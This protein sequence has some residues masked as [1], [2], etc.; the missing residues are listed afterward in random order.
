MLILGGGLADK[1]GSMKTENKLYRATLIAAYVVVLL[2]VT[3]C[4]ENVGP[5]DGLTE[6]RGTTSV[7]G[8]VVGESGL[9][10]PNSLVQ[11]NGSSLVTQA[12]GMLQGKAPTLNN[13]I[14]SL[15]YS[16][17]GL[18]VVTTVGVSAYSGT[19]PLN[20]K[21]PD[22]TEVRGAVADGLNI[23]SE[24]YQ[25]TVPPRSVIGK[26]GTEISDVNLIVGVSSSGKGQGGSFVSGT[27][28]TRSSNLL[29]TLNPMA[30]VVVSAA[31]ATHNLAQL[32]A[33]KTVKLLVASEVLNTVSRPDTVIVWRFDE[34]QWMWVRATDAVLSG[35]RYTMELSK[36]GSYVL[37]SAVA[38]ASISGRVIGA[39]G[40][41]LS[42]VDLMV[43]DA[44]ATTD[45]LGEFFAYVPS[46]T[47]IS[48]KSAG[49]EF[50]VEKSVSA[51]GATENRTITLNVADAT[52]MFTYTAVTNTGT[53]TASVVRVEQGSKVG[54]RAFPSGAAQIVIPSGKAYSVSVSNPEGSINVNMNKPAAEPGSTID[55]GVI[56][57]SQQAMGDY[58]A[59]MFTAVQGIS[60]S[61]DGQYIATIGQ[62][63]ALETKGYVYNASTLSLVVEVA[64]PANSSSAAALHNG[65]FPQWSADSRRVFFRNAGN[66]VT[67]GYVVDVISKK[68]YGQSF[69]RNAWLTP[70]G[71][72]I[73]TK[74]PDSGDTLVFVN[75]LSGV[76][77]SRFYPGDSSE[78]IGVVSSPKPALIITKTANHQ[79]VA[80]IYDIGSTSARAQYP[81]GQFHQAPYTSSVAADFIVYGHAT[82][83]L[84]STT[85]GITVELSSS[86]QRFPATPLAI[87]SN[88]SQA[89]T[90]RG[91]GQP[92][93]VGALRQLPS[94]LVKRLLIG[95]D[96]LEK[97]QCAAFSPN[98][99]S[100]ALGMV[101]A[102][103]IARVVLVR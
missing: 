96:P 32:A 78:I 5:A 77:V 86:R 80:H 22:V 88:G 98:S 49:W 8:V 59:A 66:E 82:K 94:G 58:L 68:R 38:P 73:V 53:P 72:Q 56:A 79:S 57:F 39:N 7:V 44:I 27:C 9:V 52:S 51:L 102:Q 63:S 87:S 11:F 3:G 64:F 1:E 37:G 85:T 76:E 81:L 4:S 100:Y 70:D 48:I 101:N 62:A 18:P 40:K 75:A 71:Q 47:P 93:N 26:G 21:V 91:E 90:I 2:V 67:G 30:Y 83:H 46:G 19:H 55:G 24:K 10:L 28:W 13:T 69:I 84:L 36:F 20:V 42:N 54:Y 103:G 12:S 97:I 95:N 25:V 17:A 60:F 43:S 92:A 35:G 15:T 6:T 99:T 14:T 74:K 61:P 89:I 31:D 16:S 41:P 33:G 65:Q 45:S 34:T 50:S 29:Q 23:V